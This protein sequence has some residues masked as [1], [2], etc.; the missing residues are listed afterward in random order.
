MWG[1]FWSR[2]HILFHC[3]N[4]ATVFALNKGHSFC[5]DIMK[6][7]EDLSWW[8]A[9][10]VSLTERS[11]S[12]ARKNSIADSLFLLQIARFRQLAPQCTASEPCPILTRV[13]FYQRQQLT[14][15]KLKLWPPLPAVLMHQVWE[16]SETS[17]LIVTLV[18]LINPICMQN[19]LKNCLH[20]L[21]LILG[22]NFVVYQK[23]LYW[24][25]LRR[26]F[27]DQYNVPMLQLQHVMQ[28]IKKSQSHEGPIRLPITFDILTSSLLIMHKGFFLPYVAS[29]SSDFWD[30]ENLHPYQLILMVHQV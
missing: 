24:A 1:K 3:D 30:A 15:S 16:P 22:S 21:C 17:C 29:L 12:L 2:K 28:G 11:I 23:C 19:R 13:I 25:G 5:P 6:W 8:P 26:P 20:T 10:S 4:K 7:W 18:A 27:T 14:I 9:T